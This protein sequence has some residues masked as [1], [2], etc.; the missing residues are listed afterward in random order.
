MAPRCSAQAQCWPCLQHK[1][2]SSSSSRHAT[3]VCSWHHNAQH[4]RNAG[5]TCINRQPAAAATGMRAQPC[6][7]QPQPQ[8]GRH[9]S[10]VSMSAAAAPAAHIAA[11]AA[12]TLHMQTP[13]R[14][15]PRRQLAAFYPM[16]PLINCLNTPPAASF[17]VEILAHRQMCRR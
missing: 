14:C 13:R 16:L 10:R 9:C 12:L 15:L 11:P 5:H 1:T 17:A 3:F 8:P 7:H 6:R 4:K 2:N